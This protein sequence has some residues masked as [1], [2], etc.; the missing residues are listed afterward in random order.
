MNRK[1][2]IG[3]QISCQ[4][5]TYN[6][7]KDIPCW[8]SSRQVNRTAFFLR[9]INTGKGFFIQDIHVLGLSVKNCLILWRKEPET[10]ETRR[11]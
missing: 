8:P 6:L 4:Y 5:I 3:H 11:T 10:D 1:D 7:I 9:K 2:K